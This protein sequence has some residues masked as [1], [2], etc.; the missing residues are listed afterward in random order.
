[1]RFLQVRYAGFEI[2]PGNELNGITLGGVGAGTVFENIHV[3]NGSDD[4]IEWFGGR[5]NGRF[6]AVTGAD[7]DSLDTDFGYKG[8]NQFILVLQRTNG[9]D[10]VIE[11]DTSGGDT[12]IPRSNP[13]FV[14]ATLLGRRSPAALLMRGGTDYRIFNS[15]VNQEPAAPCVQ[16]ANAFTIAA[17]SAAQDKV[18]PPIFR[19]TFFSCGATTALAGADITADQ[20]TAIL[21]G[22][23][24]TP[25]TTTGNVLAGTSTLTNGGQAGAGNW[26]PGANENAV[27]PT[28]VPAFGTAANPGIGVTITTTTYIGAFQNANDRWYDGWT[29]GTGGTNPTCETAPTP[30]S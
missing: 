29:C 12:F 16:F 27:T 11:A 10:R 6:L 28:A 14:N 15:I 7:D 4:G 24:T 25:P 19:S 13:M 2:A 21:N 8:V 3:H 20:T 9:G 1:M 18:G 17:A 23:S 26:F 5:V 30:R 22:S